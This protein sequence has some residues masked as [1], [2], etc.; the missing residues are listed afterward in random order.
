M[1]APKTPVRDQPEI[2]ICPGAPKK[3]KYRDVIDDSP[4]PYRGATAQCQGSLEHLSITGGMWSL[5]PSFRP[6]ADT[7]MQAEDVLYVAKSEGGICKK[8]SRFFTKPTWPAPWKVAQLALWSLC[9]PAKINPL[10]SRPKGSVPFRL[11]VC[12]LSLLSRPL[13]ETQPHLPHTPFTLLCFISSVLGCSQSCW[14]WASSE[15][16]AGSFHIP[17]CCFGIMEDL[18]AISGTSTQW[19]RL[20]PTGST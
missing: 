16:S 8:I 5:A 11:Q 1:E 20:R 10:N 9:K 3:P 6:L 12:C 2:P 14:I 13:D 17:N 19:T 18:R 4:I 15:G 7:V